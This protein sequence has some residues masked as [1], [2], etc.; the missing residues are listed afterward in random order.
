MERLM[1]RI[2]RLEARLNADSRQ[3]SVPLLRRAHAT[4]DGN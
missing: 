4:A 1:K 3:S 2:A